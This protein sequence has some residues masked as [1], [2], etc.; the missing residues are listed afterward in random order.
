MLLTTPFCG[1]TAKRRAICTAWAAVSGSRTVP[2]ST[3]EVPMGAAVIRSRGIA[4]VIACCTCDR[5]AVTTTW[6]RKLSP[7]RVFMNTMSVA[8]GARPMTCTRELVIGKTSATCSNTRVARSNSPGNVR[9][10]ADPTARLT[11]VH[12]FCRNAMGASLPLTGPTGMD[13]VR[14]TDGERDRD[15][16]PDPTPRLRKIASASAPT[17]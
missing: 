3:I 12:P 8:P 10:R 11:V 13:T 9:V 17:G 7:V 5:S 14:D 6:A 2:P 16:A 15:G 4:A 1:S